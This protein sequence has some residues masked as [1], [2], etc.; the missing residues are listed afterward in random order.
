MSR[1]TSPLPDFERPPLVEVAL[2]IQFD[3]L[4]S[5]GVS[6]LGL[7]WAEYKE[8]FPKTQEQ[9]PLPAV[10]ET[11]GRKPDRRVEVSFEMLEALPTPRLWFLSEA[12]DELIQV[13][14]DRFIHNWRKLGEGQEYPRYTHIREVFVRQLSA[15]CD[16]LQ[17][18]KIG[19]LVPNQCEVTYVNHFASHEGWES[20]GQVDN[21]LA[22]WSSQLSDDFL[23][24]PEDVRFALRYVIPD[25]EG[26]SAGRLHVSLQ[27]AYRSTDSEAILVLELTARG[28]PLGDGVEGA[29]RFLD[30]GHEWVVRGFTSVTTRA[31]HQIWGRK[32]K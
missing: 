12:G 15:F 16:F 11:F 21:V 13:Q 25:D 17:R 6:Q 24:E 14:K 28:R 7:L 4:S 9:P 8:R 20:H 32:D 23:P 18:E 5:L 3:A 19:E 31:I 10:T 22:V 26:N 27:P 30:L 29:L 1:T 2:S